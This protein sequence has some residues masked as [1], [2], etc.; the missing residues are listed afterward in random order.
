MPSPLAAS[1]TAR[2]ASGLPA[3][4]SAVTVTVL[5]AEPVEAA[6]VLG[7]NSSRLL[8]ALT[9]PATAVAENVTGFPLTPG[10]SVPALSVL[11]PVP[12][13][14]VQAPT[15]AGPSAPVVVSPPLTLPPPAV[16]VNLTGTPGTGGPAA[17]RR[18]TVGATGTAVPAG[19]VC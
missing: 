13:P 8:V 10:A 15:A 16:T 6:I 4:S 11:D 7:D 14:R 5:A 9:G 19:A 17:S 18:T 1:V 2:P 12:G 3:P